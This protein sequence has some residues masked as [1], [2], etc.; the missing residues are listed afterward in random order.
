MKSW[1]ILGALLGIGLAG[2]AQ[3]V[4]YTY[5][6]YDATINNGSVCHAINDG[7][8]EFLQRRATS[9][10]NLTN[11][12]DIWTVCAF[13]RNEGLYRSYEDG[14]LTQDGFTD[15]YPYSERYIFAQI[16]ISSR[17]DE[18]VSG[19]CV[20]RY[21]DAGG[22]VLNT[23]VQPFTMAP[24]GTASVMFGDPTASPIQVTTLDAVTIAC[25]LS[26]NSRIN[27]VL[28]APYDSSTFTYTWP[29]L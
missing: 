11:D 10:I 7:E 27:R 29:L 6:L 19:L 28:Q 9:L 5:E 16:D 23:L 21:V 3:G 8:T 13:D 26:R 24:G 20:Y 4:T 17:H 2:T 18:A 12:T 15:P 22:N 25:L 14:T 1:T